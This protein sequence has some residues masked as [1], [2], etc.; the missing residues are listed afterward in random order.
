MD[1]D[2]KMLREKRIKAG[3]SIADLARAVG[4]TWVTVY[5]YDRGKC[6]EVLTAKFRKYLDLI[7]VDYDS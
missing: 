2:Y 4:A 1:F 7:G 6:P 3:Y 5:N